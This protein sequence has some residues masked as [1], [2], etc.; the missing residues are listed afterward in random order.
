M[1]RHN[2]KALPACFIFKCQLKISRSCVLLACARL[3]SLS[4]AARHLDLSPAASAALK[5]LE[6]RLAVRLIERTARALRP[7]RR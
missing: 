6:S 1:N 4:A 3:G 7:T 5:K 2:R